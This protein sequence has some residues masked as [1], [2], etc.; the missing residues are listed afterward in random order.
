MLSEKYFK[1]A[2]KKAAVFHGINIDIAAGVSTMS[3][4]Q[5]WPNKSELFGRSGN[6][7]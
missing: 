2:V 6:I 5:E 3:Q 1:A 4:K 7:N